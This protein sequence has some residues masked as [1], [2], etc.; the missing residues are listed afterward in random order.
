MQIRGKKGKAAGKGRNKG[1]EK[2]KR[3]GKKCVPGYLCAATFAS[4]TPTFLTQDLTE[5]ISEPRDL[6][7]RTGPL[8]K[9]SWIP[10]I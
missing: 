8:P 5:S 1:K 4:T 3:G 7:F 10:N 9:V 6:S 2:K